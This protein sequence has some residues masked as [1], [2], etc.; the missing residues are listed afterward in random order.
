V[1]EA[2]GLTAAEARSSIRFGFGRYTTEQE[3]D[4]AMALIREAADR[5]RA[6]A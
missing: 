4:T 3:I 1:L 5:Q 6:F 2:I